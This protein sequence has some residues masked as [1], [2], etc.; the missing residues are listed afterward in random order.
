MNKFFSRV[1]M[2]IITVLCTTSQAFA[3]KNCN[4]YYEDSFDPIKEQ[5]SADLGKKILGE[6]VFRQIKKDDLSKKMGEE[7]KPNLDLYKHLRSTLNKDS[8]CVYGRAGTA[9]TVILKG[10]GIIAIDPK[11]SNTGKEE[12]YVYKAKT[13]VDLKFKTFKT[14]ERSVKFQEIGVLLGVE[15]GMDHSYK[16]SLCLVA[17]QSKFKEQNEVYKDNIVSKYTAYLVA[18]KIVSPNISFELAIDMLQ[19]YTIISPVCS[20]NKNQLLVALRG[21]LKVDAEF[22]KSGERELHFFEATLDVDPEKNTLELRNYEGMDIS[23]LGS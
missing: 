16:N 8:V 20:H 14:E 12:I 5:Y 11:N 21:I 10:S 22:S 9:S 2:L 6:S 4:F 19:N 1:V 13:M 7:A 15:N 18:R 17:S 23:V 3:N